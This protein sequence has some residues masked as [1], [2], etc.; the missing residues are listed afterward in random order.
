MSD[1][2]SL[3]LTKRTA[4]GKKVAGLRKEGQTP[5]VV[6]GHGFNA[7]NVQAPEVAIQ[8]V[9]AK[10][11]KHHMIDLIIDGD[12]KL[13]LIKDIE[14]D[15]V[16]HKLNHV[17]FHAVRA[18]DKVETSIPVKLVGVGESIAERAGLVILQTLENLTVRALPK[19]LP[20]SLEVSIVDLE[21][22]GQG[23]TIADLTIPSGVE[24]NEENHDITIASVYEPS[25]LA[26]ANEAAGGDAEDE[27]EVE[28]ENGEAA[29]GEESESGEKTDT[30]TDTNKKPPEN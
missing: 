19:D 5:G 11:G 8:K 15:P 10:A 22:P 6:Y 4:T 23:V 26:A 12:K 28:A 2:I 25:A 18:G 24:L 9:V 29:E 21:E 3:T 30:D 7:I 14:I 1:S 20:D 27:S 13:G 17:S 16:K